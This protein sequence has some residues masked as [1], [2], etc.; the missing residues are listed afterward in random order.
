MGKTM[1]PETNPGHLEIIAM[2]KISDEFPINRPAKVIS[3]RHGQI[4]DVRHDIAS[5]QK[6]ELF[7]G[8]NRLHLGSKAGEQITCDMKPH[9]LVN[10]LLRM[11]FVSVVHVKE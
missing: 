5:Q 2:L 11:R 4:N 1:N 3:N 8:G 10:A 7:S 6:G 9:G